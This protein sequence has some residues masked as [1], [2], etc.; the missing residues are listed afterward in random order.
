MKRPTNSTRPR[1]AS[2]S[3]EHA[4][5]GWNTPWPFYQGI[6]REVYRIERWLPAGTLEY[7]TRD[8]SDFEGSGR[9]EFEG[10]VAEDLRDEYVG[11]SV[12]KSSQNPIRYANV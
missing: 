9:W 7:E 12:G 5:I 8:D 10:R 3:W 11:F 2:G 4:G 6:V 1:A